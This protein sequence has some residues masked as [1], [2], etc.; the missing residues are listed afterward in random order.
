MHRIGGTLRDP[1][2]GLGGAAVGIPP[3][4]YWNSQRN[5][6]NPVPDIVRRAV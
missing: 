6:V 1:G 2:F 3:F 4:C 5:A